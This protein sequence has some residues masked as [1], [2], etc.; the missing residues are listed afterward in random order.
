M[1]D[2][3]R[4]L[5]LAGIISLVINLLN[6]GSLLLDIFCFEFSTFDVVMDSICI[7]LTLITGISYLCLAKKS[8]DYLAK[9]KNSVVQTGVKS[10]GWENK[11]THFPL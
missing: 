8:N 10:P 6:V 1:K 4:T 3:K 11:T 7:V 2:I 5:K 9:H